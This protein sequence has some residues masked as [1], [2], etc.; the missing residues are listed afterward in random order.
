MPASYIVAARRSANARFLGSLAPLSATQI[1]SQVIAA[2]MRD[3]DAAPGIVDEV[4]IGQVV[5]AGLGQNPARQAALGGGISDAV[6][7]ITVNQVCGSGLR[8]VMT[9]DR[10]V[11][12]GDVGIVLAGGMES[13]TNCPHL[14]RGLRTGGVKIG[15]GALV[16]SM[17]FDGLTCAFDHRVMG[18]TAEY[19]AEKQKISRAE[20]DEASAR[21]HQRAAKAISEG[22]FKREITPVQVP[23]R[24]QTIVFDSDECVRPD[25]TVAAL[26]KLAPYFK[27]DGTVTAGNSSSL[28]DGAAMLMVA[29]MEAAKKHGWKPR[30]KFLSAAVAGGPPRDLFTATIPAVRTAL[31]KASLKLSDIDLFEVNEAF[32]VQLV[33]CIKGLEIGHERVNADGG[34][35]GLGHPIGASGA[36]ILVTLLHSLERRNLKRGVAALCL[37]GGNA[38]AAVIERT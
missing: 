35:I 33:A 11:R 10:A 15:D 9:A 1:A 20:Q 30:A 22:A 4:V 8:A 13:M 6:T 14:L 38:V 25:T 24:K 16:D 18:E 31:D 7:A 2:V 32:A 12:S 26:S 37:G 28:A 5:Q 36:R 21:S 19:L 34:S 29:S 23:D 3:L 27:K 17:M